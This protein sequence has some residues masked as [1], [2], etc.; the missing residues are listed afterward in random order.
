MRRFLLFLLVSL[1]PQSLCAQA[2][3]T[4]LR[5][6][7]IGLLESTNLSDKAWGAHLIAS[8]HL[9]DLQDRLVAELR[10]WQKHRGV[11]ID[12]PEYAYLQKLFDA[13]IQMDATVPTDLI[14]PFRAEHRAEVMIL[15]ARNR[16]IESVLLDL[17]GEDVS[18]T[19]WLAVANTLLER[20][21]SKLFEK[22][23]VGLPVTHLF[24]VAAH[25]RP[26]RPVGWGD[27]DGLPSGP[28][29]PR[30]FPSS[31][32]PTGL[33]K[34]TRFPETRAS[35]FAPGP[36]D[37]FFD[38]AVLPS[39]GLIY[40]YVDFR[41]T[42]RTPRTEFH[43][44]LLSAL[45]G[46]PL[47]SVKELFKPTTRIRWRTAAQLNKGVARKLDGQSAGIRSFIA[48]AKLRRETDMTSVRLEIKPELH[49]YREQ[50]PDRL[51]VPRPRI[52]E[53][54]LK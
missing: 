20:R 18:D 3:V 26:L 45:S 21:S 32:P 31:F 24:E 12:G 53:L 34:L 38:R 51:V 30:R 22:L 42:V 33:Y 15:L 43:L 25:N 11:P 48:G 54:D 40:W 7:S 19:E 9:T 47:S 35:L 23:L 10:A 28:P 1:V 16:G 36:G 2:L 13:L 49:D 37:V 27:G 6:Q 14:L 46:K 5:K 39:G 8:L 41:D 4:S 44:E 17:L 29:L 50:K 52:I